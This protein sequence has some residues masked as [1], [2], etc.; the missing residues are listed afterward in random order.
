MIYPL[1]LEFHLAYFFYRIDN[2]FLRIV[3]MIFSKAAQSV[4]NVQTFVEHT[5]H[6][7]V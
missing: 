2:Y 6:Y 3:S 1:I 5:L 4:Q 7:F